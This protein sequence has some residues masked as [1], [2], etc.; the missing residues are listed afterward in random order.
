[1]Q[2]ESV[3]ATA[4]VL[5]TFYIDPEAD[6]RLSRL[7]LRMGVSKN[8]FT[9]DLLEASV[10]PFLDQHG[11]TGFPSGIAGVE[12]KDNMVMRSIYVAPEFDAYLRK[13]AFE[14]HCSKGALMR[15]FIDRKLAEAEAPVASVAAEQ[16]AAIE[17]ALSAIDRFSAAL[18]DKAQPDTDVAT[19]PNATSPRSEA[20]RILKSIPDFADSH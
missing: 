3:M 6:A 11:A 10:K 1:M 14:Q 2:K 20:E 15:F 17:R 12:E 18:S 19:V 4:M 5:R 16:P 13:A 7:A 9:R 8:Q